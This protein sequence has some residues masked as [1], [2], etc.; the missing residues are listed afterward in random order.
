MRRFQPERA[1]AGQV[2]KSNLILGMGERP[3]DFEGHCSSLPAEPRGQSGT[4]WRIAEPQC[5][6]SH[7][8][9]SSSREKFVRTFGPVAER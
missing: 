6:V 7:A 8:T 5:R 4:P 9:S 3:D 2:T 1:R